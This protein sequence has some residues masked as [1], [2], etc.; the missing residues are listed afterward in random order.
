MLVA[1]IAGKRMG[2][3]ILEVISKLS[4]TLQIFK[5]DS[6]GQVNIVESVPIVDMQ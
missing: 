6:S 4:F 2:M 5:Y 3:I 1:T